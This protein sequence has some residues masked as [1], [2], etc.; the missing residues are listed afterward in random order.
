[1]CGKRTK[2]CVRSAE[3]RAQKISSYSAHLTEGYALHPRIFYALLRE[4]RQ[5]SGTFCMLLTLPSTLPPTFPKGL[6]DSNRWDNRNQKIHFFTPM[7]HLALL[8]KRFCLRSVSKGFLTW[9]SCSSIDLLKTSMSLKKKP[10][11]LQV[12]SRRKEHIHIENEAGALCSPNLSIRHSNERTASFSLS[13]SS[14][15]HEYSFDV[16]LQ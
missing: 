15:S 9:T 16:T 5:N 7:F 8:A 13:H 3:K 6:I 11:H 12:I 4:V 10:K 2:R 14:L 1:M